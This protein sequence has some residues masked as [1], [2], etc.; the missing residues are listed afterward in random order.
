MPP[1]PG[2][3]SEDDDRKKAFFSF[4]S[5]V[6]GRIKAVGGRQRQNDNESVT[7]SDQH[8][9]TLSTPTA[10]TAQPQP[11]GIDLSQSTKDPRSYEQRLSGLSFSLKRPMR[12]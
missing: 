11:L 6:A 7:E 10:A 8:A 2:L 9:L 1:L 4:G 12:V 3:E 5:A